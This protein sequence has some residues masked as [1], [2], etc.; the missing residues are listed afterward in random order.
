MNVIELKE[1]SKSY[2]DFELKD[3]SFN[4][5]QGCILGLIGENGSGKS[6]TIKLILDMAIKD[7]GEI[8]LWDKDNSEKS[9]LF[10]EDIG[11][12]FDELYMPEN[13]HAL[14]V[15]KIMKNV[16]K[17]WDSNVYSG[18]L[19][20]FKL[21]KKKVISKLSKGMKMK[22]GIAIALSHNPKLLILDEATAGLDPVVRDDVID[23]IMEFTKDEEHS[24]LMS[25]HIVSDLEK[26][27]DYIAFLHEGQLIMYEEKDV[28][29]DKYRIVKG[30]EAQIDELSKEE[31]VNV[32]GKKV[33]SFGACALVD[34]KSIPTSLHSENITIEDLFI[35]TVRDREASSE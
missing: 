29:K 12:V 23:I 6:T 16:N 8:K 4:L 2:D 31:G 9:H 27:C 21:P 20:K 30:T 33:G 26:A 11:V 3:I 34:K 14:D 24:V 19:E 13:L 28:L 15:N 17:N 10:M 25:S 18:Y 35:Y 32:I 5:P 22:L 7:S 1:V